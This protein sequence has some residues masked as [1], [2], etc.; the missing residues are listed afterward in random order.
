MVRLYGTTWA[1]HDKFGERR[2]QGRLAWTARG[3]PSPGGGR[4]GPA[5]A[6]R[7]VAHAG[8]VEDDHD[9]VVLG[10]PPVHGRDPAEV[11]AALGDRPPPAVDEAAPRRGSQLLGLLFGPATERHHV[12]V[13]AL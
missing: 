1:G 5:D 8:A 3:R 6:A 12:V 10:I 4:P 2:A 7:H 11:Q 9:L 13:R